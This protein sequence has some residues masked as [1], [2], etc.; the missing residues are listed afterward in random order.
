[1]NS[2]ADVAAYLAQ[3]A[4]PLSLLLMLLG[5]VVA[6]ALARAC[7]VGTRPLQVSLD[8]HDG[9]QQPRPPRR[10]RRMLPPWR[11]AAQTMLL[12]LLGALLMW[13][14]SKAVAAV[15]HWLAAG[16]T[17]P[18]LPPGAVPEQCTTYASAPSC[19]IGQFDTE[20]ALALS[21]QIGTAARQAA[22]L[23]SHLGDTLTITVLGFI[24]FF[25][26]LRLGRRS[27]AI[28]WALA[29]P[30]QG[31]L[32]LHA[33]AEFARV[34]PPHT[35]DGWVV[36]EGFSFPSGHAGGSTLAYGLLAYVLLRVLPPRWHLAVVGTAA[37]LVIGIGLTRVLLQVHYASDVV[38]GWLLG[39][40]WLAIVITLLQVLRRDLP[41]APQA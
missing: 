31:L 36:A 38:A 12:L 10:W 22:A 41:A 11:P 34:R 35:D 5:S 17:A 7:G 28:G 13:L 37:A 27:L 4:I 9:Q 6:M 18:A 19:W 32:I 30:L 15:L 33:K 23:F 2:P 24:V 39:G 1:M 16:W 21:T 25:I 40:A 26:L 29:L 20:L 3:R 8:A 14:V